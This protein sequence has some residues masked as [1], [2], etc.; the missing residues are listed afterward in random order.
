MAIQQ[1]AP[2]LV[3]RLVLEEVDDASDALK[4]LE[5]TKDQGAEPG[6]EESTEEE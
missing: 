4:Q 3:S 5:S 2:I 6:E 1:K